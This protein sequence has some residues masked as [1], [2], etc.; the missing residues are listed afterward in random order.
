M[1]HYKLLIKS[2]SFLGQ[3][4]QPFTHHHAHDR[5][6][7]NVLMNLTKLATEKQTDQKG[8]DTV[9]LTGWLSPRPFPSPAE[10]RGWSR[11]QRQ[12]LGTEDLGLGVRGSFSNLSLGKA[13]GSRSTCFSIKWGNW[14]SSGLG[15]KSP[16]QDVT[17]EAVV[18]LK[19][20]PTVIGWG[21]CLFKESP[22]TFD[23][24]V[25]SWD[26]RQEKNN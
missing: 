6:S 3:I 17:K 1:S 19:V 12:E 24:R 16:H 22:L 2:E 20:S 4:L 7:I 21:P 15:P 26:A 11:V 13:A 18:T 8:R 9:P 5:R 25:L 23:F 14:K 10:I